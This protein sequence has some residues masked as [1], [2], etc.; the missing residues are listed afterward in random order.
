VTCF[1]NFKQC[2]RQ[3]GLHHSPAD[4][5]ITLRSVKLCLKSY[6]D[7]ICALQEETL[8]QL[9]TVIYA[10]KKCLY[11]SY[12]PFCAVASYFRCGTLNTDYSDIYDTNVC[13]GLIGP[14]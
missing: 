3:V 5:H 14:S 1:S 13:D 10:S 11:L 8:L 4:A 9:F 7:C 6:I 12:V 2:G